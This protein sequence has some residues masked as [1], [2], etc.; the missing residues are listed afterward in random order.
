MRHKVFLNWVTL[1][2]SSMYLLCASLSRKYPRC[3]LSLELNTNALY[4]DISSTS[5]ALFVKHKT[6]LIYDVDR[7]QG[8]QLGQRKQL[9][10]LVGLLEECITTNWAS[11]H[12]SSLSGLKRKAGCCPKQLGLPRNKGI[13]LIASA[14]CLPQPNLYHFQLTKRRQPPVHLL[15]KPTAQFVGSFKNWYF[16]DELACKQIL[17]PLR[18]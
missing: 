8:S 16:D 3:I 18:L 12:C 5:R 10:L 6:I 13:K 11:E 9:K 1:W 15:N 14:D 7:F 2:S 17:F 4:L